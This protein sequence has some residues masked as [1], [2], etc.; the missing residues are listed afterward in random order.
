[1]KKYNWHFKKL[2]LQFP[3][4]IVKTMSNYRET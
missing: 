4:K 2:S 3:F 1:M